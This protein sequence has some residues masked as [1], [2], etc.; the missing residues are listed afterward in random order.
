MGGGVCLAHDVDTRL[1]RVTDPTSA[2]AAMRR[3]FRQRRRAVVDDRRSERI[4]A[5]LVQVVGPV[6][7][8]SVMV[9]DAVA[10]EPDLTG[11]VAWCDDHDVV[12][13]APSPEPTADDPIDPSAVDV[14]V[15]PGL[16]FTAG[17]QRLGQGG[18]WYDRFLAR[19]RADC[20]KIGVG[21]EVQVVDELPTEAH[22][23]TLDL[24]VTEAGVVGVGGGAG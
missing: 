4:C 9:F 11:F 19:T 24:V 20:L 16:A 14:V 15:V 2:K 13:S 1:R 17:G 18:G 7:P 3:E 8:R 21:F 12:T 23:V 5:A 6:A 10:G 22:D